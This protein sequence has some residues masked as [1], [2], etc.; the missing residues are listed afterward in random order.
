MID[1][2]IRIIKKTKNLLKNRIKNVKNTVFLRPVDFE[3][4]FNV[5]SFEMNGKIVYL[6]Y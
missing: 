6:Q 5:N 4:T 3:Y 1:S 2:N